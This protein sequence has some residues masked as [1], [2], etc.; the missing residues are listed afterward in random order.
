[1]F[2]N[3]YGICKARH[4]NVF[5]QQLLVLYHSNVCTLWYMRHF[6]DIELGYMG[7]VLAVFPLKFCFIM[8]QVL[9]PQVHYV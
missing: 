4:W 7:I 3:M 9:Q 1:M 6:K 2:A 5:Y 8:V